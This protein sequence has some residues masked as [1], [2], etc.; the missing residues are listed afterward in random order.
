MATKQI[1]VFIKLDNVS[2]RDVLS[3]ILAF[4]DA[5]HPWKYRIFQISDMPPEKDLQT[6]I[7]ESDGFILAASSLFV[8]GATIAS[9]KPIVYTSSRLNPAI[10]GP[11]TLIRNDNFAIGKAGAQHLISLGT[12]ASYAFVHAK[13]KDK[14]TQPR[15]AGF[16]AALRAKGIRPTPHYLARSAE[17]STEEIDELADWLVT[18]PKPTAVMTACDWRALHILTAAERAGLRVP[19]QLAIVGV[20]NDELLVEHSNPPLTSVQPGHFE[21]GFTAARELSRLMTAR[22]KPPVRTICVPPKHVVARESTRILPPATT[23]VERAKKFIAERAASGIG[24]EDVV[25]HLGCSRNL[26]DLRYKAAEG[27]TIHAAIEAAR[28]EAV[29]RLLKTTRRPVAAIAVQ[30]GFKSANRLTHLFRQ[31]FGMTIRDW[32]SK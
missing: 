15:E 11:S 4:T 3:G 19:D 30:C 29:K 8:K 6:A 24:V 2:G 16:N 12:F 18:L 21:I 1:T 27:L 9:K 25:A 13:S 26:A 17:G 32:R 20:D 5:E 14:Y 7:N 22:R 28:L 31:R 10:K 23:L